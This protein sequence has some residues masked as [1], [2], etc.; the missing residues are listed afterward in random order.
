MPATAAVASTTAPRV[1]KDVARNRAL[2]LDTADRLI[3]VRGLDVT[4]HELAEAAGVGVGTVYRHFA[5]RNALLGALV[6]QRFE[7]ARDIL[8]VAEQIADPVEALRTAVLRTCEHQCSDRAMWQAMLSVAEGH[9]DLAK[10]RLLPILTRIV[11][12][13]R[14]TGRLRADFTLTDLPMIFMLTGG[15]SRHTARTQPGVW[16]RYVEAIL[17]GFMLRESDRTGSAVPAAPTDNELEDI[18][19]C[20]D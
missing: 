17:D 19:S 2:L 4:F 15:L 10:E 3:A 9:R 5:D 16:R 6:E 1:R 14:S 13:A 11:E 7:A 20:T 18:I 8:L 12:R